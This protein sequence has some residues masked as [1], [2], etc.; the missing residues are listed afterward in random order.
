MSLV[1]HTYG[2]GRVRVL[3]LN[4]T[5]DRHEVR[6][7]TVQAMMKGDFGRIFT[8]ADNGKAVSTDTVKNTINIVAREHLDLDTEAFCQVACQR[9]LDRYPQ[10][11]EIE[12]TA[13]E[14]KWAR[15]SV[16]GTPH[17]HSFVLDGNGKP[18]ATVKAPRGEPMTTTSGISDFTFMKTTESGWD[19]FAKDSYTTIPETRDRICATSLE[20][21]WVWKAKPAD[22]A[23]SNTLIL[24][25]MLGVF[26]T[27][28]SES[29][30][31][32]L[33]RMA[34]AALDTVPE[35]ET[36][37]LAAP[38][39]H[40]LLMNLSAFDLTNDNRVFLPT[41]EPYG[42]IECTVGRG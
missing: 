41:D 11:S 33:Y 22:Y 40:Y 16:D 27:T 1:A 18:F 21:S 35:I 28:Y 9:F 5:G 30:Q 31:D 39:K 25:T 15:L 23:K 8:D 36:I 17:P 6:E 3:R 29:V 13:H 2:K 20:A 7:L 10:I 4:K 42:Q 37:S 32:S 24:D 34:T 14:T 12:I 19:K 26:A 38:N